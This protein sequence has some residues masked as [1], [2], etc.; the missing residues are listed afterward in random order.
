ML[1]SSVV[2]MAANA[3]TRMILSPAGQAI[4]TVSSPSMG[5]GDDDAQILWDVMNVP[6][7]DSMM[8]PGKAIVTAGKELNFI[9]NLRGG[10]I[11][12]CTVTLNQR[13]PRGQEWITLDPAG[14]KARFL[15][16]GD[17]ALA[18]GQKLNLNA[19]GTLKILS[20]DNKLMLEYQPSR[21]EI[22]YSEHGI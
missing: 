10:K 5:A 15:I 2:S 4:M 1:L 6:P 9:C 7:Q 11:P 19:D 12:F 16:T 8:G 22:L 14:K 17:E 21:L 18:L 13:G 3:A 20:S